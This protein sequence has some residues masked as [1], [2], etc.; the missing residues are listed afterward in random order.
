[1]DAWI[2]LE[3]IEANGERNRAL[4]LIKARGLNHSNQVREYRITDTGIGLIEPYIGPEG[5]LTGTARL[6]QAASEQAAATRRRKEI[7]RRQRELAR[8]REAL[9]RQICELRAA[10]EA[11]EE[12]A[13]L[14]LAEEGA[15][16][17]TRASDRA[18]LA[19]L[20]GAAE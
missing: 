15:H 6:T 2:K 4:Y 7:E 17:A 16:E 9:E 18:A 11:E 12:E 20:R 13:N 1:M 8:H 10:L 19:A 14:L 3:D 5:V